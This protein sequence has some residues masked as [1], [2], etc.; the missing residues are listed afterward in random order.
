MYYYYMCDQYNDIGFGCTYRC[1]QTILSAIHF[2]KNSF[3]EVPTFQY[4][5]FFFNKIPQN[6]IKK[7]DIW[8]EPHHAYTFLNTKYKYTGTE[9]LYV[10]NDKS[11][12]NILKTPIEI[13]TLKQNKIYTKNN[14][15]IL[16]NDFIEYFKQSRIPVII[17]NGT[18]TYLVADC[19]YNIDNLEL[20]IIDPHCIKA[21]TQ[22]YQRNW[23]D[24][25]PNSL[26]MILI[27]DT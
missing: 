26:W 20:T 15:N 11:I 7:S 24:F 9:I 19:K 13:Y 12:E 25:I 23:E 3:Q 21:N 6:V 5:L 18:Y 17:D 22:I 10:P 27:L 1:I 8:L 4:L 2:H 14:I 16:R